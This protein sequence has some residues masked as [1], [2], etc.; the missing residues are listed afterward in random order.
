[1]K[2]KLGAVTKMHHEI[3]R[4]K[5]HPGLEK[6]LAILIL[7]QYT[8]DLKITAKSFQFCLEDIRR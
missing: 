1:M 4:P 7:S 3:S 5:H 2:K 8:A 6:S